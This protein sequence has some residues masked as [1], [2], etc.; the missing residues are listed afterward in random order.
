MCG[1]AFSNS[2]SVDSAS[3]SR[4]LGEL[5]RRGPNGSLSWQNRRFKLGHSLLAI[6]SLPADHRLLYE[7]PSS[8][9]AITFNGEIYNVPELTQQFFPGRIFSSDTELIV[10][11]FDKLGPMFVQELNG[12]FAFV[13]VNIETEDFYVARDRLGVKPLYAFWGNGALSLSST[14]KSM[15]AMI[16]GLEPDERALIEYRQLRAPIGHKTFYQGLTHFP[17]ATF[18]WKNTEVRYWAPLQSESVDDNNFEALLEDSISRQTN[19]ALCS[20]GALLSGG[21]DSAFV[22]AKSGAVSSW[23]AGTVASNEFLESDMVASYLGRES[24][25]KIIVSQRQFDTLA[26]KLSEEKGEPLALPNEVLLASLFSKVSESH[27]VVLAGEGADEIMAGYSRVF[28]WST[29][30]GA[31]DMREF[32]QLYG[33]SEQINLDVFEEALSPHLEKGKSKFHTVVDFFLQHHLKVLLGRMDFASMNFG[34][35]ARVP[36]L[37]HRLV[38]EFAHSPLSWK[39]NEEHT[40]APLR[41]IASRFIGPEN[42]YRR[43]SGFPVSFEKDARKTIHEQYQ[44]WF[45]SQIDFFKSKGAQ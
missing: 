19:S 39:K 32:A 10:H 26:R 30:K 33:Y 12:I 24:S 16:P 35:E 45:D 41:R 4:A 2:T 6:Q 9:Y 43:K 11:L 3:F 28:D 13:I 21:V 42:A 40:K 7:L 29:T 22:F 38:D 37:D 17:P 27:K 1:I 25:N 18:Y 15:L 14:V 20:V 8:Q 5:S 31:F 36:F 34:V 44:N 23:T